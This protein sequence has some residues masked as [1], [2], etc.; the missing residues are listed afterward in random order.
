MPSGPMAPYPPSTAKSVPVTIMRF[1]TK[2][3]LRSSEALEYCVLEKILK[4]QGV[5][6]QMKIQRTNGCIFAFCAAPYCDCC[7]NPPAD[8]ICASVLTFLCISKVQLF[9][10]ASL[11]CLA[12]LF[13][14]YVVILVILLR[15][16][17]I[18]KFIARV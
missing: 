4:I 18:T 9:L 10:N 2:R 8:C 5:K 1:D 3:C 6:S 12:L 15:F 16:F 13:T 11:T 7:N 14:Y 17:T